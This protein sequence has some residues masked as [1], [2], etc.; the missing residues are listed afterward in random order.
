M[1]RDSIKAVK[2]Y[3]K[4]GVVIFYLYI[5]LSIVTSFF[6]KRIRE[7]HGWSSDFS[8]GQAPDKIQVREIKSKFLNLSNID[9]VESEVKEDIY[10]L[11]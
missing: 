2:V 6:S 10:P 8:F 9:L 11:S 4:Y 5:L 3:S 1:D 7:E